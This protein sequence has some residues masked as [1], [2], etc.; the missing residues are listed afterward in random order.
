MEQLDLNDMAVFAAIAQAGGITAA[1]G[2]MNMPKSN[3]SRRLA[4]LE[5]RL[6]VQLLERNTRS[7]RLTSIG[8]CYADH[9]RLMVEQA[10][11]ADAVV[12]KS[13]AEPSGELRVSAS[14]LI[15]QQLI[16]PAVAAYRQK[17]PAVQVILELSNARTNLIDDG[18]DLAFRIGA[19]R[20]S[21]LIVQLIGSF[22]FGLYASPEYLGKTFAPKHP[23][24]LKNHFC[25]ITGSNFRTSR[26]ELA[27]GD[28]NAKIS[29]A[30]SV[31]A[32]DFLTL[33]NLAVANGGIAML[34]TYAVSFELA[35]GQLQH[36]L[37][38][39]SG[40]NA[41]LSVVY[42]SRRGATIKQRDFI[43]QVKQTCQL[44]L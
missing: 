23:E 4:R 27:S 6:G 16:A 31:I 13:T 35:S 39:W 36:V 10:K 40:K 8:V 19:N 37:P 9:C 28:E 14:V 43:K 32:N 44:A 41:D 15:G 33:R 5:A 29:V 12:E 18:F 11:A 22:P 38:N 17:Y 21:S 20:D 26:W 1:A 30:G 25:L 2:K 34:P 3:V 24:E 7:N 42:P